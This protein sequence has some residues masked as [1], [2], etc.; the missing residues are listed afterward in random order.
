MRIV[1]SFRYAL[2]G[3]T[4]TFI[5]YDSAQPSPHFHSIYKSNEFIPYSSLL[6]YYYYYY[7]FL[8]KLGYFSSCGHCGILFVII[9]RMGFI[10]CNIN[11]GN[12]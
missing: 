8:R 4:I 10:R 11:D 3:L 5:G 7:I 2:R 9:P 12:V 6:F 1:T